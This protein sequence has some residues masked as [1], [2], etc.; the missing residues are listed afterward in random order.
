MT[1]PLRMLMLVNPAASQAERSLGA[2]RDWLSERC[3]LE[4]VLTRSSEE[5]SARIASDGANFDRVI[6]GGGDGTLSAAL[7]ALLAVDRPVAVLPLGTANDF[8]RTI[9]VPPDPIAA[10]EIALNGRVHRIDIGVVNG[11]HFVNV[12]S[13]GVATNVTK[14]QSKA[15]KRLWR[16]LSYLLTLRKVVGEAKA[17][18]VDIEIDGS[19]RWE[20]KAYQVSV[21]NGR[22]H[23]GGMTVSAEAALDD[24]VLHM[25]VVRPGSAM[26]VLKGLAD[27][28]LG[29]PV[30]SE[31]LE[32][33]A[34][35]A[36]VVTT[37]EPMAVN[38]DGEITTETPAEFAVLRHALQII[39]PQTLPAGQK[40]LAQV[41]ALPA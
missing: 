20:G 30:R 2:A 17:F 38:T 22:H 7:P 35:S 14:A 25:Y 1:A 34:G 13:I 10:A 15:L 16:G 33:L 28:R 23:G 31:A 37:R 12:A 21:G 4:T 40:G 29:R 26:Q 18:S 39:V 24:G 9:S 6:L 11:H 36:A 27:L 3:T 32:L 5:V 41:D 8:A 19:D